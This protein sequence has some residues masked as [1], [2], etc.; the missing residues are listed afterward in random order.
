MRRNDQVIADGGADVLDAERRQQL[1]ELVEARNSLTVIQLS[2]HFGVSP[3][4]IRR[5]L[6]QLS[7]RGLIERAHGG[8][9]KRVRT[10][11]HMPE[12]PVL[13]RS[14]MQTE[15][16]R[17]I[18]AAA[19][20]HV[21]D[22]QTVIISSGTTT[23]EMIPHLASRTGLTVI[24]NALN[25]VLLLAQYPQITV[26]TLGGILR[27]SEMTTLGSLAENALKNLRAD[28]LFMGSRAIHSDYGFSAE[29]L[30][31]SHSDQTLMH[32]ANETIVIAD[33]TKFGKV[34]MV[35]V[36]PV[37]G[38]ARIITD[39]GVSAEDVRAFSDQGVIVEL[40]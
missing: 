14:S 39:S 36:A 11:A 37:D 16:K 34:A 20:A 27:H 10:A 5:D 23:A 30:A 8:A 2:E 13:K 7:Q 9:A 21:L 26:I 33:H 19:A 38:V 25:I 22:G 35:R 1:V 18:G 28:K 4:T 17:R 40:A 24:T 3:A 31:E 6:S 29:N 32:S 12:P 15:E